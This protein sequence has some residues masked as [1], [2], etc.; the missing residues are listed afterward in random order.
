[1]FHLRY[2]ALRT[3]LPL[4]FVALGNLYNPAFASDEPGNVTLY[5][6]TYGVPYIFAATDADAAYGLGYAQAQDRL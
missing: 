2:R 3:S 6:D 4:L 5:R 1:M